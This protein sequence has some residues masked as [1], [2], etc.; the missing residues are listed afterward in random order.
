MYTP[1]PKKEKSPEKGSVKK[2]CTCKAIK[3][4]GVRCKNPCKYGQ[5]CGVHKK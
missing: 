3:K 4:D 2:S 1:I 5:Y